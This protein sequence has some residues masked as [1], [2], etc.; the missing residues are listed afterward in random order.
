[1]GQAESDQGL[2]VRTRLS[3]DRAKDVAARSHVVSSMT[4][5]CGNRQ[6][7]LDKK[8]AHVHRGKDHIHNN[9]HMLLNIFMV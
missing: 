1:M 7:R 9:G 3:A 6:F 4:S 8:M 2:Q 5:S